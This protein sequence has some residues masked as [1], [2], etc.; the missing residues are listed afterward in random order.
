MKSYGQLLLRSQCRLN[1]AVTA[2]ATASSAHTL[3]SFQLPAQ[4]NNQNIEGHRKKG[5]SLFGLVAF[6][7][8][9]PN[10]SGPLCPYPF[11]DRL[12]I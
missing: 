9:S 10:V 4:S 1:V 3:L 11:C 7:L 6:F 12:H 5:N 2:V 8:L